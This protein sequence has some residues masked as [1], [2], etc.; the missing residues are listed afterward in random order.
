MRY[1]CGI[2]YFR[3]S[4]RL[5]EKYISEIYIKCTEIICENVVDIYFEYI[6]SYIRVTQI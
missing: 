4:D 1:T 5:V 2:Q 3:Y 6:H